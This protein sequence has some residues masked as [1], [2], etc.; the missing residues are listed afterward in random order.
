MGFGVGKVIVLA[1]LKIK[2]LPSSFAHCKLCVC[3]QYMKVMSKVMSECWS[4]NPAA[5]LT[6]LRV[7]KTLGKLVEL[8]A[9][10]SSIIKS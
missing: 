6:A 4:G 9:M 1:P 2:G 8:H 10:S 5:R 7:K 3:V